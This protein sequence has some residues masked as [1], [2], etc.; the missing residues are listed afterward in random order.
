MQCSADDARPPVA[1]PRIEICDADAYFNVKN[2]RTLRGT[3][4]TYFTNIDFLKKISVMYCDVLTCKPSKYHMS[5]PT[6]PVLTGLT[7]RTTAYLAPP[8]LPGLASQDRRP[9]T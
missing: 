3:Q 4:N 9:H 6:W 8:G 2:Y 1:Y 7:R 5:S